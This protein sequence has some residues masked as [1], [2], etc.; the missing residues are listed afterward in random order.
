M[1]MA[2]RGRC[3]CGHCVWHNR[4]MPSLWAR[5]WDKIY[6]GWVALE[7]ENE[8][9]PIEPVPEWVCCPYCG[10]ALDPPGGEYSDAPDEYL[11][12]QFMD[13]LPQWQR[14]YMEKVAAENGVILTWR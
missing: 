12:Q 8:Y 14:A 1:T 10:S 6:T 2:K 5:D 11:R 3:E 7:P 9:Y 13:S 4:V